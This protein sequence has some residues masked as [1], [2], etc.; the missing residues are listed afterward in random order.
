MI[1]IKNLHKSYR[2][3]KEI[4][5]NL[6][7]SFGETGLTMIVGKSGCGKT[8]LLNIVGAM[9]L[10]FEG[11]VSIDGLD[12]KEASYKEI[13]DYRNFTSAFVFQKNS[14]F[15]FLTVEENLKLCMNIQN[16]T[17]DI[18][19]ALE[20]VGL[21]GFERKKVKSLSGGEKQRV[22]IARALI[23]NC[24]II[25]ADEPTSALD[26]KNAHKIFQLFKE[27]SKDKLVVLVTHERSIAD[28]FADR[29]L[30]ISDGN[31]H[32]VRPE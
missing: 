31:V 19:E 6:N 9:D 24:K 14:L 5:P 23:K 4:I 3:G 11:Q 1:E 2:R 15:E 8:T 25:F 20:K 17:A 13:V 22:A 28:F 16:N 18:S 30:K 10:D 29:I 27:I 12:L 7:L 26:T 21:K 32:F